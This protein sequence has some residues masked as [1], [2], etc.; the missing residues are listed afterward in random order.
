MVA[1]YNSCEYLINKE[2]LFRLLD[3][4][5]ALFNAKEVTYKVPWKKLNK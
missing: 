3:E 5:Q 1:G 4:Y 2:E